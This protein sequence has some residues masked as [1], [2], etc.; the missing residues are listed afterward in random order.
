MTEKQITYTVTYAGSPIVFEDEQE[1][2][3]PVQNNTLQI[4]LLI[5]GI[6]I[7]AAVIAYIV[8]SIIRDRRRRTPPGTG[9]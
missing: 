3:E 9:N 1:V 4:V 5:L 7:A 2:P 8:I 6:V